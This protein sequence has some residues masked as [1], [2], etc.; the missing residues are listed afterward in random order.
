[1]FRSNVIKRFNYEFINEV[2]IHLE[3]PNEC[4]RERQKAVYENTRIIESEIAGGVY[5]TCPDQFC[6]WQ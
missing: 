4:T 6:L 5:I 1:M 2:S 3:M